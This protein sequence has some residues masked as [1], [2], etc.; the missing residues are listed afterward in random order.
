VGTS[1]SLDSNP[2]S[3]RLFHQL[4]QKDHLKLQLLSRHPIAKTAPRQL[5]CHPPKTATIIQPEANLLII[6][7]GL[8]MANLFYLAKQR[9]STQSTGHTLA[10]LHSEDSF[11]FTV[12]PARFLLPE[13]PAEAIGACPLLEDWK[14]G[15]RL[16][17][18]LGLPGC[19][20]GSLTDLLEQWIQYH[21]HQREIQRDS[22]S[23]DV[24]VKPEIKPENWLVV[25]CGPN[26]M[27]KKCLEICQSTD[28][29]NFTGI[30]YDRS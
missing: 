13:M 9:D 8:E 15:N 17:S 5:H 26:T 1:F 3:L 27:Q 19:F 7:S 30:A 12:K 21:N 6:A 28:W 11:P 4:L 2:E 23:E 25:A 20:D 18:D 29:L 16:A 14:I 24:G 10:L 22:R